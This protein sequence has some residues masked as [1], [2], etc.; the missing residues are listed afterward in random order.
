[1]SRLDGRRRHRRGKGAAGR[2]RNAPGAREGPNGASLRPRRRR[3]NDRA[4]PERPEVP[5]MQNVIA[6]IEHKHGA[7][8]RSSLEAATQARTLADQLGGKALAVVV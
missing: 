2:S 3:E 8:R 4:I 7:I 1:R 6:F 5:M